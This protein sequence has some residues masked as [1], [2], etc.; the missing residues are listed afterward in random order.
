MLPPKYTRTL[1]FTA[2]EDPVKVTATYAGVKV[3]VTSW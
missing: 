2:H 1:R 3:G